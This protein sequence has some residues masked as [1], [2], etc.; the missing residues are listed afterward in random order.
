VQLVGGRIHLDEGWRAISAAPIHPVQH[1]AVQ[2]N[3][4]VGGR[5]EALNQRD[6]ATVAFVGLELRRPVDVA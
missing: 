2:V 3:V 4:E 5:P 6:G 1:E